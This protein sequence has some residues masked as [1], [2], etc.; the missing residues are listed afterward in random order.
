MIRSSRFTIR[1]EREGGEGGREWG[2][3]KERERERERDTGTGERRGKG[4]A[5]V[6]R[7]IGGTEGAQGQAESVGTQVQGGRGRDRTGRDGTGGDRTGG[8]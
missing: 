7:D 5:R 8:D 6:G 1:R 3:E 4:R 2:K